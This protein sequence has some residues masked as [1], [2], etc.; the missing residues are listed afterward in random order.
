MPAM[1][2]LDLSCQLLSFF[3]W[4][5]EGWGSWDFLQ[6]AGHEGHGDAEFLLNG[7][8]Q[9][10][11]GPEGQKQDQDIGQNVDG[12]G[13]DEVEVRIDAV[14]WRRLVPCFRHGGALED[15]G[16]HVAEVEGDV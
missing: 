5:K 9:V 2:A 8:V 6:N 15:D 3:L 14:A 1:L 7:Q 13:D 12:A 16:E 4:F 11:D 10:P